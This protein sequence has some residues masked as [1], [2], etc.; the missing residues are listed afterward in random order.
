MKRVKV[1]VVGVGAVGVEMLRLLKKRRFPL[2][3]L[4][5]FARRERDIVI[6]QDTYH[7]EAITAQGFE[8]LDLALFAGTEGEK[9]ASVQYAAEAINRGCLVIDNGADFR[10]KPDVP[11]VIPEVNPQALR[12]HKGII[13]NPNCSTIQMVVAIFPIYKEF[14]IKRIIVSTYQASSGAGR[15]AQRQLWQE[16]G[17][18]V[19]KISQ[20]SLSLQEA[21]FLKE[22]I[23]E[24]ADKAL[25]HQ[26]AFNC[27]PH[28]GGFKEDGY[29]SE[30]WKMVKETH[31]ILGDSSIHISATCVRIPVFRGHSEAIYIETHKKV[32]LNKVKD[33]LSKSAA[34]KL[35]DS[36]QDDLYPQ[37]LFC[38][39]KEE[40]F[41]GRIRLD[42]FNPYG[43]WLWV[44][45][46]NLWKGAS[47]NAIQIAEVLLKEG[48]LLK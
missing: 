24:E 43:L 18:I 10:M 5:V 16:T 22:I 39:N 17:A 3:E 14:G 15:G 33:I 42:P 28:I 37:P 48:L 47:L 4:R 35:L 32:D 8:G 31:K 23:L 27:F 38:A 1:G 45:S 46:D 44:V 29:T 34:V 36:P 6:D 11:L 25:P 9:G 21:D 19:E 26:L 40:V 13:S 30:E 41:V 7:V 2:Q 20:K 12:K